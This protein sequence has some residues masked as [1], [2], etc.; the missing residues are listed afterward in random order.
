MP[1]VP[2]FL[3]LIS[4]VITSFGQRT[5]KRMSSEMDVIPRVRVWRSYV[6][7]ALGLT[8]VVMSPIVDLSYMTTEQGSKLLTSGWWGVSRHPN[9]LCVVCHLLL[10][11]RSHRLQ[12]VTS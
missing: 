8:F 3:L 10:R 6:Y 4:S 7:T 12:G 9:Y 2:R 5:M 11:P 1:G